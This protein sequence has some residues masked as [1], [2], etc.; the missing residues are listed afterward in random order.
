MAALTGDQSFDAA[1]QLGAQSE[2]IAGYAAELTAS[3]AR[4]A[5]NADASA[6][7]ANLIYD[8]LMAAIAEQSGV[9]LDEETAE[10]SI[11]EN[12]YSAM[13]NVI[14]VIQEMYDSLM[15]MV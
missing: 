9:N 14:Q 1:G 4:E 8:N 11:L 2:S 12:N 3:I 13:A 10:L 5:D 15:A 6:Q 7:S